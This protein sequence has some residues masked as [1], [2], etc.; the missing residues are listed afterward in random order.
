[1]NE[2]RNRIKELDIIRGITLI[3]MMVY[4]ACWDLGYLFRVNMPWYYGKGAYIWEQSICW[5]FILLSGYCFHL[6]KQHLKRG[7]TVFI[8][9]LTVT[10]VTLIALPE[11]RI[12]FGV[13]TLLGS[14]MLFAIPLH[15]GLMRM[16]EK[17]NTEKISE[18]KRSIGVTGIVISSILFVLL[19]NTN[20]GTFGFESLS[21]GK[22]PSML[23]KGYFLTYLGF[24]DPTFFSTDY[25]SVI[26]WFFLF[27]VGYFF[28][29]IRKDKKI[30]KEI[31]C[32][33]LEFLGRNS[34]LIYMIHQ[35]VIYGIFFIVFKV[36]IHD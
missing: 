3:S 23:Y 30:E 18:K 10:A 28:F 35:P 32:K 9:G 36:I 19:R 12:V 7:L 21:F 20:R 6:G 31:H 4:H 13:L 14:S 11:D 26:P 22:I 1:M 24:T 5:T 29:F 27:L 16:L 17:T 25:F 33:P 2:K 34:L 15:C 8:G